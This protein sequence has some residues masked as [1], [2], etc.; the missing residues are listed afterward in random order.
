MSEFPIVA[1]HWSVNWEA[2]VEVRRI[3]VI[4]SIVILFMSRMDLFVTTLSKM[5]ISMDTM[6]MSLMNR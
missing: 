1:D 5:S 4:V 2:V 3:V 6:V